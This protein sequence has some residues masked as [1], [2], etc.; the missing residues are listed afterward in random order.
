MKH[1]AIKVKTTAKSVPT[2]KAATEK[3]ARKISKPEAIKAAKRVKAKAEKKSGV[4]FVQKRNLKEKT[5]KPTVAIATKSKSK[6]AKI[7]RAVSDKKPEVKKLTS[8]VAVQKPKLKKVVSVIA[9][10]KPKTAETKVVRQ[11]ESPS[12]VSS[13]KSTKKG[14]EKSVSVAAIQKI[15]PQAKKSSLVVVVKSKPETRKIKTVISAPKNKLKEKKAAH[16]VAIEKVMPRA[17]KAEAL[18]RRITKSKIKISKV[19]LADVLNK[20]KAIEKKS[21]VESAGKVAQKLRIKQIKSPVAPQKIKSTDTKVE[22]TIKLQKPKPKKAKPIGAAVFRGRRERY[23]FQVYPLDTQFD[24]ISAI[25]VI[26]KRKIDRQKKGHH[27]LV[28]IGQTD[29]VVDELKKHTRSKCV[30]KYAANVISILPE[31][32]EKRRLKIE[33]DLKAAHTIACN[34]G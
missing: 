3:T 25:Y 33:E 18:P 11:K 15:K 17:K 7:A 16:V 8:I 31:A 30:K 22:A 2:P 27:A 23:D 6:T 21:Q 9:P 28:C 29:S 4:S 10:A 32:N 26:S 14:R 24:N 20:R 12:K 34:I 1:G 5:V 13:P 19:K